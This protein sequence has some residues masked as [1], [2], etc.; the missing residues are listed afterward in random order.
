M[1]KLIAHSD[2]RVLRDLA[3]RVAELAADPVQEHR[4][5]IWYAQN[6]LRP[7]RPPVVGAPGGAGVELR[8]PG[9]RGC[10]GRPA[11]DVPPGMSRFLKS[12]RCARLRSRPARPRAR[13]LVPAATCWQQP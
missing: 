4:R 2:R 11:R 13:P 7:I 10:G 5:A 1:A 12:P 9:A 8:P 3:R 6:R